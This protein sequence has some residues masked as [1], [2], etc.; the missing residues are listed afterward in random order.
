[1][2]TL[3]TIFYLL[4]IFYEYIRPAYEF[5]EKKVIDRLSDDLK[6]LVTLCSSCNAK[7]LVKPKNASVRMIDLK[8]W[9]DKLWTYSWFKYQK[10]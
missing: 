8:Q 6:T 2:E 1:M 3:P 5:V 4:N 7:N 10:F 9:K